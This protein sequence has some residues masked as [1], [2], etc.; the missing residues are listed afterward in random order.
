MFHTILIG[1]DGSEHADGALRYGA[2]LARALGSRVVVVAGYVHVPPL[3]G[4][5]GAFEALDRHDAAA[6]AER[7]RSSIEGVAIVHTVIVAGG[8]AAEALHRAA[9]A[10]QADLIVVG[11]SA[12]H[13]IAGHQP[14]SVSEH[15]LHHSPCA[16]AVV[17]PLKRGPGLLRIGVAVDSGEPAQLA[18]D[19]AMDLAEEIGNGM[20]ELQLFHIT[21]EDLEFLR[22]GVPGPAPEYHITPA[23]LESMAANARDRLPAEIVE[24]TGDPSHRLVELAAG[25]DLLVTGS[26]DQSGIRRLILGSVS[27][28]VV[29]NAPC[30][31]LVIPGHGARRPEPTATGAAEHTA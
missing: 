23:W 27:A 1:V 21:P 28:S 20:A 24:D 25:L 22:P 15:V 9:E 10:E 18:L 31:V 17:P 11:T 2:T 14:G 4:D 3:R 13:R 12:R 6:L 16:V 7:A 30:P 5:G 29:R 19:A 26:R 8:T